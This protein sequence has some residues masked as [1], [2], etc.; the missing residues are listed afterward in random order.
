MQPETAYTAEQIDGFK[1]EWARR[2]RRQ[3]MVAIV[4]V[5]MMVL[6]WCSGGEMQGAYAASH[7]FF[8]LDFEV[9]DT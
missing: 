5:A 7:D 2:R 9:G 1:R 3:T 4:V 8:N 6:A